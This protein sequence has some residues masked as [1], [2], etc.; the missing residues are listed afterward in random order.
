LAVSALFTNMG[1]GAGVARDVG[2]IWEGVLVN[3]N[4]IIIT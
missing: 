2:N 1:S 4:L 3:A